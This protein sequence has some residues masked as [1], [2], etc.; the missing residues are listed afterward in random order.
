MFSNSLI[1]FSVDGLG[2]VPYFKFSLRP[3]YGRSSGSNGDHLQKDFLQHTTA[4]RTV[5]V[6][7]SDTTAG[8]CWPM[9]PLEP[10]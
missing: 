3:K 5:V 2:Y 6:S 1:Q 10:L 4:S 9:P 8:H 7:A